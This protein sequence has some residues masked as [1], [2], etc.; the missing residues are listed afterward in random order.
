MNCP[1]CKH[2]TKD[3]DA[4][5]CPHCGKRLAESA[6]LKTDLAAAEKEEQ[7]TVEKNERTLLDEIATLID[8]HLAD[9]EDQLDDIKICLY[10]I[11]TFM[12]TSLAFGIGL[13]LQYGN[14]WHLFVFLVS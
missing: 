12:I 6:S 9:M 14:L 11:V 5:W 2:E 8:E 10:I 7:K 4:V 3:E 1:E 13:L